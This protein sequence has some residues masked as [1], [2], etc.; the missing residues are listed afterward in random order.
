MVQLVLGW[1]A[2]KVWLSAVSGLTHHD[3]HLIAGA[4]LT[5][6]FAKLLR[7]KL[8]S[9]RPLTI[10]LILELINETFDFAR[11]AIGGYP[12]GPLPSLIDIALT[13]VPGVLIVV[14]ARL[15][16]RRRQRRDQSPRIDRR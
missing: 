3:I 12:W 1:E 14:C 6:V 13:M 5:I 2:F 15:S 9:W 4:V 11:Y 8:A 10:V 16:A 7:V